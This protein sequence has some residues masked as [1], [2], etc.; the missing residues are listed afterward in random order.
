VTKALDILHSGDLVSDD[1]KIVVLNDADYDLTV[2]DFTDPEAII[3]TQLDEHGVTHTVVISRKM[4]L[5]GSNSQPSW[6]YLAPQP[7][8][9]LSTVK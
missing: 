4:A 8:P 7:L 9:A 5:I 1:P 2:V 6:N 3:I